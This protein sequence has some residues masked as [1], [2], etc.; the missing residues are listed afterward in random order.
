MKVDNTIWALLKSRSTSSL[1]ISGRLGITVFFLLVTF[2]APWILT[3]IPYPLFSL[4]AARPFR[5]LPGNAGSS[6]L[7]IRTSEHPSICVGDCGL[8]VDYLRSPCLVFDNLQQN[9][10]QRWTCIRNEC[11]VKGSL[12]NQLLRNVFGRISCVWNEIG[13]CALAGNG[14]NE[15]RWNP[16]SDSKSL[17]GFAKIAITTSDNIHVAQSFPT[18]FPNLCRCLGGFVSLTALR[19]FSSNFH[20]TVHQS[21]ILFFA[22]PL[23]A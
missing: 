21:L 22:S 4:K 6:L 20:S 3:G 17:S 13:Y 10:S 23:I 12:H 7:V 15:A 1:T 19:N 16:M 8:N 11:Y 2:N 9:F 18:Y 5:C 14:H